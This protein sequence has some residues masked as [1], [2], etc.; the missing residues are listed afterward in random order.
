MFQHVLVSPFL[1][2]TEAEEILETC[3]NALDDLWKLE[4]YVY[5]Q[6]RMVHLV[7]SLVCNVTNIAVTVI[8]VN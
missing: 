3:Q 5:P 6:K 2:L 7:S 8:A 4:D 1:L